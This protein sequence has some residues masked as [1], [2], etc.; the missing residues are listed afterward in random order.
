MNDI[1]K[2]TLHKRYMAAMHAMQSGV[3]AEQAR[4]G[5]ETEPKHLRVGVNS[6]LLNQGALA[7]LLIDKGIITDDEYLL[8]VTEQA[9]KEK[10]AYEARLGVKLI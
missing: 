10:T 9:E 3:A 4:G 8:A 6:A 5:K 7:K 1:E 2:K